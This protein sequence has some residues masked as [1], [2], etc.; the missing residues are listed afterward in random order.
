MDELVHHREV[1]MPGKIRARMEDSFSS[2]G[3]RPR[4]AVAEAELMQQ[5]SKTFHDSFSSTDVLPTPPAGPPLAQSRERSILFPH[6]D[7]SFYR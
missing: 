6:I 5:A 7:R 2:L 4:R 3:G 1:A